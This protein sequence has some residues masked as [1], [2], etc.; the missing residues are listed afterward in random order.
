MRG[1]S[2][3]GGVLIHFMN[4]RNISY[5]AA[6]GSVT[7]EPGITWGQAL[8]FLEPL[9]VAV[10]GG[11]VRCVLSHWLQLFCNRFQRCRNGPSPWGW[12]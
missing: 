1:C 10:A 2:V 12:D 8:D 6:G 4:M 7:L 9:G 5:D 3:Q 11:R